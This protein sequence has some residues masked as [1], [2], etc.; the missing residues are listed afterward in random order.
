MLSSA[1]S[2]LARAKFEVAGHGLASLRVDGLRCGVLQGLLGARRMGAKK[3]P[4]RD[5]H[6][7]HRAKETDPGRGLGECRPWERTVT[8]GG[9]HSEWR[10]EGL[11]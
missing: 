11:I 2:R 3:E 4:L 8:K 9:A 1:G 6:G 7:V 5:F 10:R